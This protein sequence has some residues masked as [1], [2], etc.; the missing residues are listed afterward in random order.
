MELGMLRLPPD[1]GAKHRA[2]HNA[3]NLRAWKLTIDLHDLLKQGN[4][5]VQ[6]RVITRGV[7]KNSAGRTSPC[8]IGTREIAVQTQLVEC[9]LKPRQTCAWVKGQATHALPVHKP[10]V[11]C[12]YRLREAFKPCSQCFMTPLAQQ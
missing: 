12:G 1:Q 7:D 5:T 2:C 11:F 3:L 4:P 6:A 9:L 10:A 8:Q